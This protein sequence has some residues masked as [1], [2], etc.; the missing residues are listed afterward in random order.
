M[1]AKKKRIKPAGGIFSE[2]VDLENPLKLVF[3]KGPEGHYGP[4]KF[5]S[6]SIV[7]AR[8]HSIF[9]LQIVGKE[10]FRIDAYSTIVIPAN[11]SFELE[12]AGS[13][14]EFVIMIPSVKLIEKVSGL[15]SLSKEEL[16]GILSKT[17]K[18]PRSNWVNEI[19]HRYVYE[20]VQTKNKGNEA[21]LFLESEILKE[22]YYL[23]KEQNIALKNRFNLDALNLDKKSSLVRKTVTFIESNL[24]RNITMEMLAKQAAAS[25]SSVQRAFTKELGVTPFNYIKDRRLEEAFLLLKSHCF[26]VGEVA[27][28]VGY[29]DTS[30]FIAAFKKKF[31]CTPSCLLG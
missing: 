21:C 9:S 10:P 5:E 26:S 3:Q 25:I 28:K 13:L 11:T 22:I 14:C 16:T 8:C 27:S 18:L 31:T 19:M 2:F 23:F 1:K 6:A 20:R 12:G 4:Y 7:F 15:Y 30:A 24:F 29:E 17:S